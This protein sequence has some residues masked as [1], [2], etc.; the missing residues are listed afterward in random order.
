MR[1]RDIPGVPRYGKKRALPAPSEPDVVLQPQT[2]DSLLK[3]TDLIVNA[4]RPTLGPLPRL[5]VMEGLRPTDT[6]QFLDDAATIARRIIQIKPRT[7]DVGAMLVRHA[8]WQMREEAGDGSATMAVIYQALLREGI[9]AVSQFDSNAMLL[10]MGFERGLRAVQDR[11]RQQAVPL[12]G[13][14]NIARIARGMCQNDAA[15]AELLG[16]VFD[17]VGPDGLIV[18]EGYETLGQER[19]YIEGTYWKLSGWLSRHFVTEPGFK[20][21]VFEDAAL[22]IT[23]FDLKDPHVLVPPLERCVKA[24]IKHLVIVA[25]DI[26]DAAIGLLVSNNKAGAI[27][28]MVV[29]TPK[30]QEMDRV[31]S[32]EDIAILTGGKP[33]YTA[34][35]ATLEDFRVEDLGQAR[36]AWATESLFGIYGGKGDPRQIRRRIA[37]VK[38]LLQSAD[39]ESTRRDLQ[40]RLGRLHGGTV[41]V[42]L[43]AIHEVEREARK[44]LAERAVTSIRNAILDGVV[45]GG[46]VA[47]IN[48][49]E[50]LQAL[51][52]ENEHEAVALRILMRALEEPLRAI[53]ANAGFNADVVAE[54]VKDAGQD[55]GFDVRS[56]KIINMREAGI[57]DPAMV[58]ACALDI[59]VSGAS[60]ALTTDVIV[61]HRK[62]I[63]SVEP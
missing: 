54:K 24:G 56:G 36:R 27:Q 47:L 9:R 16:E 26:S 45:V 22:L 4:I 49:Q 33:F 10:R 62:P 7:D 29:R 34:A 59:A 55:F 19:E 11:L 50:T 48:A 15:L 8:M 3:G 37:E 53:T 30:T 39:L 46:G 38:A 35:F 17:I 31:A 18:I 21:T 12:Q 44:T 28:T 23:D 2:Y 13:R 43:G 42:R 58:V 51:T 32:I 60:M 1:T 40:A 6:P 41:I 14:E 52:P 25:R 5:V 20:R 63:E 57:M 61:H